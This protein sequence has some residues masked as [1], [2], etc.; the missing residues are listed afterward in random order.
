MIMMKKD[1]GD[2]A[3]V[4]VTRADND[5]PGALKRALDLVGG[6]DPGSKS[7]LIKPNA[8]FA[9]RPGSGIVT[10]P[11]VLECVI[12][13]LISSGTPP[14]NIMVGES[15]SM[16]FDTT[17]AFRKIGITE[18]CKKHGVGLSDFSQGEFVTKKVRINGK[19]MS[20]D[21]AK[22]VIEADMIINAPVIKTHF[23]TG[24]S[25]A[26]KNMFG[27]LSFE[28][29]KLVHKFALDAG[30]AHLSKIL[31]GYMTVGDGTFGLEGF[32]PSILGTPGKWGLIFASNDPVAHDATV[33]RLF[34]VDVPAHVKIASDI[35]VGVS[36]PGK[37]KLVGE[38]ADGLRRKIRP[39][40]GSFSP[41]KSVKAIDG[42]ACAYCL[43]AVYLVLQR[44]STQEIKTGKEIEILFG[45]NID[46]VKCDP[47][48]EKILCGDCTERFRKRFG[49]FLPGCPPK[50]ADIIGMVKKVL[51]EHEH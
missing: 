16:G 51:E 23:Q 31:P 18:I 40:I 38:K 12:K 5:I 44:L 24:V 34:G 37:I 15:G 43:Y 13:H 10:N 42:G 17:K 3:V 48:K 30:I 14:A 29:R 47:K 4:A 49:N 11:A 1:N 46:D 20:L 21:I 22:D 8:V 28:S 35:G 39:A 45:H 26:L 36:D 6:V 41:L 2:N 50:K 32:G 25:M 33:C 7:V 9:I 27:I 19:D